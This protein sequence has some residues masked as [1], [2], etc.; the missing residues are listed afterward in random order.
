MEELCEGYE[1]KYLDQLQQCFDMR[2]LFKMADL[3]RGLKYD[4]MEYNPEA[5]E[6]KVEPSFNGGDIEYN[7]LH[8]YENAKI[9]PIKWVAPMW[10][11]RVW[12]EEVKARVKMQLPMEKILDLQCSVA[13][14]M[15]SM[16]GSVVLIDKSKSRRHTEIYGVCAEMLNHLKCYNI[17]VVGDIKGT[18]VVRTGCSQWYLP[19]GDLWTNEAMSYMKEDGDYSRLIDPKDDIDLSK[20][21]IV[22]F[23]FRGD[24]FCSRLLRRCRLEGKPCIALGISFNHSQFLTALRQRKNN[25]GEFVDDCTTYFYGRRMDFMVREFETVCSHSN[26]FSPTNETGCN[27]I[28]GFSSMEAL[29]MIGHRFWSSCLPITLD[30]PRNGDYYYSH[31]LDGEVLYLDVR[32]DLDGVYKF[33]ELRNRCRQADED[34]NF[35]VAHCE[36]CLP[37]GAYVCEFVYDQ[38][39]VT[40]VLIGDE[41][42]SYNDYF[43]YVEY[44]YSNPL[45]Y[46]P[47][48]CIGRIEDETRFKVELREKFKDVKIFL[49][50][51][52]HAEKRSGEL[53]CDSSTI[54]TGLPLIN[55]SGEEGL[56]LLDSKDEPGSSDFVTGKM[57][58]FFYK[59]AYRADYEDYLSR[60]DEG[61]SEAVG[62]L[63]FYRCHKD[64]WEGNGVYSVTAL[65]D[66]IKSRPEKRTGDSTYYASL[67][68]KMTTLKSIKLNDCSVQ[69]AT[70]FRF[71][72]G[73]IQMFP[74][75][76]D[77][78]DCKVEIDP[79]RNFKAYLNELPGSRIFVG[80][81]V[82]YNGIYYLVTKYKVD[83]DGGR[84]DGKVRF[85]LRHLN[86]RNHYV[87]MAF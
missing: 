60:Y 17:L 70:K 63:G 50:R 73:I 29:R 34:C 77:I 30:L 44:I 10:D 35:V 64:V 11:V 61:S 19:F 32:S 75:S 45:P 59:K 2:S 42:R 21:D 22:V 27:A 54:L 52:F 84:G 31:K 15:G 69:L 43:D 20:F 26:F 83:T 36:V 18:L 14:Q 74:D 86:R 12:E 67:M 56:V 4:E 16:Q 71:D 6:L 79:G 46:E 47:L 81:V 62:N 23:C 24:S 85:V 55:A 25:E 80:C 87:P 38:I 68:K 37:L 53:Y 39:W 82:V 57:R 66:V 40:Q 13:S 48:G 72:T 7:V 58:C 78:S 3:D 41:I 65:G 5:V 8:P 49:K 28:W 51:W 1:L 9:E 76:I 33:G